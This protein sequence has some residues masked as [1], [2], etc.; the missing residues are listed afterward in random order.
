MQLGYLVALVLQTD[1]V[2][3]IEQATGLI[4]EVFGH[5]ENRQKIIDIIQYTYKHSNTRMGK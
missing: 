5:F 4:G 2:D 1:A 3:A